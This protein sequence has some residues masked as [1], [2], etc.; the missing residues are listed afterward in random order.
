MPQTELNPFTSFLAE[1]LQDLDSPPAVLQPKA[2]HSIEVQHSYLRQTSSTEC[3]P[4]IEIEYCEDT[5][6]G[7]QLETIPQQHADLSKNA[8]GRAAK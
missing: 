2:R 8:S 3:I 4:A 5:R 1:F 7:Q 6:S